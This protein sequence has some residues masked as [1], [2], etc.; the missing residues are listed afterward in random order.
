MMTL[1]F[2][3]RAR[4]EESP[5]SMLLRTAHLNGFRSVA[6]M[7]AALHHE[8]NARPLEWQ[9]C[10]SSMAK[11]FEALDQKAP[12][13]LPFHRRSSRVTRGAPILINNIAIPLSLL[14]TKE[15]VIC[16]R[17]IADGWQRYIQDVN[18]IDECPYHQC[19]YIMVCPACEQNLTWTDCNGAVCQCGFDLSNCPI[20]P[21]LSS[22]SKHMLSIF[23]NQ[24][25][26]KFGV[27]LDNLKAL[28]YS[29]ALPAREKK[30]ILELALSVALREKGSIK[31]AVSRAV[32]LYAAAPIIFFIAPW[33]LSND[34]EIKTA[35]I[36]LLSDDVSTLTLG[37]NNKSSQ[38]LWLLR[39][40]LE[41]IGIN[42]KKLHALTQTGL[43]TKITIKTNTPHRYFS[44]DW[45]SVQKWLDSS[46]SPSL[47]ITTPLHLDIEQ[48]AIYLDV[49]P[50]IVRRAVRANFMASNTKTGKS[51]K[52]LLCKDE[53]SAFHQKYI[54]VGPLAK[55]LGSPNT[56]LTARLRS[57]GIE[58]ISGPTLDR[59]L[60]A[61][62][63][64]STL[65]MSKIAQALTAETYSHKAGRK[66]HALQPNDT[67]I[68]S[69]DAAKIL[70]TEVQRLK[71]LER[72]GLLEEEIPIQFLSEN[73]R[74]FTKASV[75]STQKIL[76]NSISIEDASA[77]LGLLIGPLTRRFIKSGFIKP[78]LLGR[79]T[80]ITS[81]DMENMRK[82]LTHY[83]SCDQLDKFLRAPT[84]HAANLIATSRIFVA[85]PEESGISTV[86][87]ISWTQARNLAKT[88]ITL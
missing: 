57:V 56:T 29:S 79:K 85:S 55:S 16:P 30:E 34:E 66:S 14:R 58:P 12:L 50:E 24:D 70:G 45:A 82:N 19:R 84:G 80:L 37:Q 3:P 17:C 60:V 83:C 67:H 27:F 69:T 38:P 41:A 36:G 71:Y 78:L 75:L 81:N 23:Q 20:Q 48:T 77:R 40:E 4:D 74:Y 35:A 87:L 8:N 62:Y 72:A 46:G 39:D 31:I 2:L 7:I 26:A 21:S 88:N 10:D 65:D 25:H 9:L 49:Y 28:R 11:L 15:H 73:R 33:L 54:F 5:R 44:A 32:G 63:Q 6:K 52:L 18:F 43:I 1:S 42:Q 76:I 68:S 61:I 13:A 53:V 86:R 47:A 64:R 51:G 22:F 59:S